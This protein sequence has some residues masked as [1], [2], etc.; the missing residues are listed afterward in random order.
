MLYRYTEAYEREWRQKEKAT[1][2]RV[3]A[4]NRDLA[5]ARAAQQA[6]RVAAQAD[7]ARLEAQ[8]FHRIVEENRHIEQQTLQKVM[9]LN[10]LAP[11][12]VCVS[13]PWA[14]GWSYACCI[15]QLR[16]NHGCCP[17]AS[18]LMCLLAALKKKKKKKEKKKVYRICEG[19]HRVTKVLVNPCAMQCSTAL[20]RQPESHLPDAG[21]L[22]LE[23]GL[24]LKSY[25]QSVC[26]QL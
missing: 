20:A 7:M 10:P 21:L 9:G 18:G 22:C 19:G 12:S 11:V 3:A 5:Q 16:A 17:A 15:E 26:L 25:R 1:R 23:S 13:V 4:T 6:A 2:E 24:C 14:S 8:E